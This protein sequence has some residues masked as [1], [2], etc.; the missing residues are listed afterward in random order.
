M[1]STANRSKRS[2]LVLS[3]AALAAL[4]ALLVFLPTERGIGALAS[5]LAASERLVERGELIGPAADITRQELAKTQAYIE[6]WEESAPSEARLPELFGRIHVLA[7]QSGAT[8]TQFDPQPALPY[9][10]IR[11]IPV[12]VACVGSFGQICRFLEGLERLDQTI[13]IESLRMEASGE[14]S[15]DVRCDL[16]LGVFADNQDNSDQVDRSG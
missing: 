4:Y 5:Q 13:W 16:I 9:A 8:A 2:I 6:A 1:K 7:Q 14:D 10:T 3:A 15:Q 12:D 11:R